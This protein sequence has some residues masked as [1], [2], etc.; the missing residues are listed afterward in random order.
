VYASPLLDQAQRSTGQAPLGFAGNN[1]DGRSELAGLH[2]K[3]RRRMLAEVH[4]YHDAVEAAD[5]GHASF[6]YST[7]PGITCAFSCGRQLHAL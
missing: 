5:D 6:T 7:F 3:M 4:V 2:V 1:L